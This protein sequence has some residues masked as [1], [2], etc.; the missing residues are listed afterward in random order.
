MPQAPFKVISESLQGMAQSETILGPV[1]R[2]VG[3]DKKEEGHDGPW[4]SRMY[5]RLKDAILEFRD[6]ALMILK[7]GRIVERSPVS[8]AVEELRGNLQ[9]KNKDSYVFYLAVRDKRP[10]RAQATANAIARALVELLREEERAP[11]EARLQQLHE[12]LRLKEEQLTR[13][14][15]RVAELLRREGIAELSAATARDTERWST[16]ETERAELAARIAR[17]RVE[18]ERAQR[19]LGAPTGNERVHPDD[20]RKIAW[21]KLDTEIRLAGLLAEE[22]SLQ[23]SLTLLAR[24]LDQ[25][26][27]TRSRIE[28]LS[29]QIEAAQRNYFQLSEA[30]QETTIRVS[31]ELSEARILAPGELPALPVSPIKIYHV[32]LA[33]VLAFVVSVGLVFILDYFDVRFLISSDHGSVG[34]DRDEHG[35][36]VARHETQSAPT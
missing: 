1:V 14:R 8:R 9:I 28:S 12:Q 19:T 4:Y 23:Q 27:A 29:A 7:Y 26:P 18:L 36:A 2:A 32:A 15:R 35:G 13:N 25:L 6:D 11:A 20:L 30:A 17:E 22:Q 33:T 16:L 34:L 3:L 10:L 21:K 24:R 5:R 31:G